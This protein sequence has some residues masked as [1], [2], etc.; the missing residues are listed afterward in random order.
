MSLQSL[1]FLITKECS[2]YLGNDSLTQFAKSLEETCVETIES[3]FMTK[4][5]A[6]CIKGGADKYVFV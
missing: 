1:T 3:G 6:I 2:H 5:L 4:D